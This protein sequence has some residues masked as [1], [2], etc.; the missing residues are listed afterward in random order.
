MIIISDLSQSYHKE[1]TT[2]EVNTAVGGRI[3]FSR[4]RR[5]LLAVTSSYSKSMSS[6]FP[7]S[8]GGYTTNSTNIY[9]VTQTTIN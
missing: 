9:R 1:L 7:I 5:S 6:L 8:E 3:F 2:L 4:A